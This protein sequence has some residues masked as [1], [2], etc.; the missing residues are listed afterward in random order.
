MTS[1]EERDETE[2][3]TLYSPRRRHN[4]LEPFRD[5]GP[6]FM[7]RQWLNIIFLIG[8]IAALIVFYTY[9]REL[10]IYMFL[11]AAALKF[12]E[13]TLRLMKL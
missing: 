13:L 1:G 2:Y 6:T 5:K 8:A 12:I 9:S 3:G 4:H 10:G 11:G 7:L